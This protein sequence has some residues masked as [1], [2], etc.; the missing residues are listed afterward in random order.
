[1]K[2]VEIL[3]YECIIL[4]GSVYT[5][6]GLN[7]FCS[8]S[9]LRYC[10]YCFQ[11]ILL[12]LL[13]TAIISLNVFHRVSR[14]KNI[15]QKYKKKTQEQNIIDRRFGTKYDPTNLPSNIIC[16]VVVFI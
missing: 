4:I 7:N 15:L 5:L 6:H 10:Q 12:F 16:S 8:I 14:K 9:V 2:A 11:N 1:M 3:T 13:T